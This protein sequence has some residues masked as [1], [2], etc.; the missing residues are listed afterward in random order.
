[1]E[2]KKYSKVRKQRERII[3]RKEKREGER[4]R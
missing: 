2:R 4:R 1:M 3:E